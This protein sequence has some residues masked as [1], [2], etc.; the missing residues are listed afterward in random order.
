M[1]TQ[2]LPL[3]AAQ[4]LKSFH[5]T[6]QTSSLQIFHERSTL[7]WKTHELGSAPFKRR[8]RHTLW[9]RCRGA[10]FVLLRFYIAPG[11]SG[12]KMALVPPDGPDPFIRVCSFEAGSLQK[13]WEAQ[14]VLQATTLGSQ[15]SKSFGHLELQ[16]LGMSE[17]WKTP[18]K[19][20]NLG[21]LLQKNKNWWSSDHGFRHCKCFG[22]HRLFRSATSSQ[23]H[24]ALEA[25][26]FSPPRPTT[27]CQGWVYGGSRSLRGWCWFKGPTRTGKFYH[28]MC[29]ENASKS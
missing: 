22:C 9:C 29:K 11:L 1:Q 23:H 13:I 25:G 3:F 24:L 26:M 17:I 6:L 5:L 28:L 2:L 20:Q 16:F 27:T 7:R 21:H 19:H 10:A 18:T 15:V 8:L 12:F 4:F 14:S